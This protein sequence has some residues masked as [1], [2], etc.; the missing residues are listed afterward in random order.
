MSINAGFRGPGVV[1]EMGSRAGQAASTGAETGRYLVAGLFDRGPVG[2]PVL[3]RSMRE[4][5]ERFGD[6]VAY[7]A[8]W[9]SLAL[10][11]AE[12]GSEAY[13]VRVVGPAATPGTLTLKDAAGKDTVRVDAI[14]AG[15]WSTTISVEVVAGTVA[16]TV[17][18]IVRSGDA[19]E[20]YDNLLSPADA[21]GRLGTSR[22]V[23]GVNMGSTTPAPNNLPAPLTRTPLGSG[24][25]DR[26]AVTAT[27]VAAALDKLPPNLGTGAV[28]L[29][30]WPAD[31][32][33]AQLIA[34]A[35]TTR[36]V[37]ILAPKVGA[38]AGEVKTLATTLTKPDGAYAML[39]WP[40]VRV[41]IAP[42]VTQLV[43][44]EGYVAAAR[45]RAHTTSGPWGAVAGPQSAARTLAGL[46]VEVGQGDGGDL[47]D[48]G[49]SVVR[50]V[51]GQI[52]LY[53]YRSLSTDI[54]LYRLLSAQD[55]LNYLAQRCEDALSGYV[56]APMNE[57]ILGQVEGALVG[58]CD[59]VRTRGGLYPWMTTTPPRREIDPGYSVDVGDSLNSRESLAQNVLRAQV[60]V[61]LAEHAELVRLSIIRVAM[62]AAV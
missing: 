31:L 38:T 47:N 39:A 37:A 45:S 57:G 12:G 48:V 24:S 10:Y 15:A 29:P 42:G 14:G 16:G 46:E 56:F 17:R 40:W 18:L 32:V 7:S 62:T 34:H 26:A 19:V 59:D 23:R 50:T 30:G 22:L 43:S 60:A 53:G 41:T 1:V 28:A 35:K 33:G 25:D 61:R 11:Y 20:V 36:R 5:I 44:P 2:T 49:V 51:A 6:R 3:V 55:T 9:D 52:M 13:V 4:L 21:A 54:A 58:I 8:A 27:H